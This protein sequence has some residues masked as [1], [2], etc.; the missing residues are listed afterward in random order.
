MATQANGLPCLSAGGALVR[1]AA[2][3]VVVVQVA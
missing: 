3:A 1:V 2:A